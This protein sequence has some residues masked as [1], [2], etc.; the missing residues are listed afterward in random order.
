MLLRCWRARGGSR[1]CRRRC[2]FALR[3]R[4]C[5]A[6]PR[7]FNEPQAAQRNW[8]PRSAL[9]AALPPAVRS[10]KAP[11][12]ALVS[13][14]E[15]PV[16]PALSAQWCLRGRA[17]SWALTLGHACV[18]DRCH[19]TRTCDESA[20]VPVPCPCR[21][22]CMCACPCPCIRLHKSFW[23]GKPPTSPTWALLPP[24][25]SRASSLTA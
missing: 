10:C 18:A 23:G 25:N 1:A 13:C 6:P 16:H 12:Y 24:R 17:I 15:E 4:G 14:W 3:G 21:C 2:T 19:H 5:S 20:A 8:L 22:P 7:P 9:A 11:C